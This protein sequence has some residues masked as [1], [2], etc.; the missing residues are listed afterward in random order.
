MCSEFAFLIRK[1]NFFLSRITYRGRV[2]K[3]L[4]QELQVV[5]KLN[6]QTTFK[7]QQE[8]IDQQKDS[9]RWLPRRAR[10][11]VG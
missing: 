6:L 8:T 1:T 7:P 2:E 3:F 9:E 11:T 5:T 10:P 4:Q